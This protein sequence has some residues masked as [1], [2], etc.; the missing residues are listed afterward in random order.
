MKI[1]GWQLWYADGSSISSAESTW[2]DAPQS[3]V[4]VLKRYFENGGERH[5]GQHLQCPRK[6]FHRIAS[7]G[8]L[9]F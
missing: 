7:G 4:Q 8:S 6:D 5:N 1:V 3:G 2:E 9:A